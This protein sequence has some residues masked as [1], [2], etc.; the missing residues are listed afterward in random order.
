MHCT[1]TQLQHFAF[2][3]TNSDTP[4]YADVIDAIRYVHTTTT[5]TSPLV[6]KPGQPSASMTSTT[7]QASS[8]GDDNCHQLPGTT[9][10]PPAPAVSDCDNDVERR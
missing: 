9:A 3:N 4:W 5:L 2:D 1:E 10:Q 6:T 7:T 8:D